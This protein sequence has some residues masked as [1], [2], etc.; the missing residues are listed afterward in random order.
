[1]NNNYLR[2]YDGLE[3]A[4]SKHIDPSEY[5]KEE[6]RRKEQELEERL[7]RLQCAANVEDIDDLLWKYEDCNLKVQD[8]KVHISKSMDIKRFMTLKKDARKCNIEDI[9]MEVL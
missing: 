3:L 8:N 4:H 7:Y 1:M 5:A 2:K 6:K 9:I